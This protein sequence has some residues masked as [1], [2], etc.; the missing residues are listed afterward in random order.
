VVQP[1]ESG[2]VDVDVVPQVE[3]QVLQRLLDLPDGW[4]VRERL[5]RDR[6][7]RPRRRE[8]S[9]GQPDHPVGHPRA[10]GKGQGGRDG[11]GPGAALFPAE[12]QVEDAG[13]FP[14]QARH[15]RSDLLGRGRRHGVAEQVPHVETGDEEFPAGQRR[16]G[17]QGPRDFLRERVGQRGR[18]VRPALSREQ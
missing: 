1:V 16:R 18:A 4:T 3:A 17:G 6:G 13:D 11:P 7:S 15:K 2:A 8:R 14:G 5:A 12:I 10:F 9:G